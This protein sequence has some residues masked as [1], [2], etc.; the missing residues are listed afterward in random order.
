MWVGSSALYHVPMCMWSSS[1]HIDTGYNAQVS[2]NIVKVACAGVFL[3]YIG[4]QLLIAQIVSPS[5]SAQNL[6]DQ[7]GKQH[8]METKD[9]FLLILQVLLLQRQT[10]SSCPRLQTSF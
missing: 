7:K 6:S 2:K 8:T 10:S 4:W 9:S 3:V 1:L 5:V